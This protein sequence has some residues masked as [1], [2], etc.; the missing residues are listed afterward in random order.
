M[1]MGKNDFI[2]ITFGIKINM[3]TK[4]GYNFT[5]YKTMNVIPCINIWMRGLIWKMEI[6]E[7]IDDVGY[8]RLN[9]DRFII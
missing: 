3:C 7:K 2:E 8:L 1:N 9:V 6:S 4:Y 5:Q